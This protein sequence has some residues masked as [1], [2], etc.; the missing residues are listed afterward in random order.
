MTRAASTVFLLPLPATKEWG[1]GKSLRQ[2]KLKTPN[3]KHQRSSKLEARAAVWSLEFGISFVFGIWFFVL[4]PLA[5]NPSIAFQGTPLPGPL[6]A[7]H[8]NVSHIFS[9]GRRG[10]EAKRHAALDSADLTRR[11]WAFPQPSGG[12]PK[13]RRRFALPAQS[14]TRRP[15]SGSW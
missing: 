4:S 2:L 5:W 8:L 9:A 14:R 6:P 15:C 13:R 11:S 3:R 7:A 12:D 10:R 1:E